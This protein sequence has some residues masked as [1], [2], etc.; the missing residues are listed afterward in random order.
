VVA[1]LTV[2][3]GTRLLD[4]A[5]GTGAVALRAA[6]AGADAVGLDLAP[7]QLEKARAAAAEAGLDVRFDEGDCQ[8]LPY[9]DASFD[10][11]ASAFGLI[12]A[13]DQERTAA[14][15]AR[16]C[17]PGGKL[18]VTAWP[19]DEWAQLAVRLGRHLPEGADAALWADEPHVR[20]LLGD[21]FDLR[22]ERGE[23]LVEDTPDGLWELA[24]TGVPH[25]RS[26]LDEVGPEQRAEAERL[27]LEFFADGRMQR[28]Y[29]LVLGTRR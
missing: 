28:E 1:E 9:E 16:V 7:G 20:G 8:A 29:V 11:V 22:F 12:F 25:L 21:A 26:W 4:V 23:W 19:L 15:A 17:R 14:E 24:S 5:T 13:P 2:G 10:A 18:G 3:P 27:H 6:A